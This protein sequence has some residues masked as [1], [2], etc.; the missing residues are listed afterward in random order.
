MAS[1]VRVAIIGLGRISR[2]HI[3]AI[4][5]WPELCELA[6]VIDTQEKLAVSFSE[7]F[8]VPYY[9]S[10]DEA[11][12][13][14]NIDAVVVCLPHLLHKE[15]AVKAAQ[16]GKHVLVE[17]VMAN[18]VPDGEAMVEAAEK[19]GVKLM[20]AQSRRFFIALQEAR[21]QR[22]KIGKITNM[23]YTFACYFDVNTAP[24]WWRSKEA[25]GGLVYPMLGSH[26]ID[27]TLWM[28][29]DRLPVSVFAQGASNNPDF[30][31]HDDVTIVIGFDDGTHATN[32]LSIN[33]RPSRHE[34]LMIGKEG[35]IYFSQAGDHIGLVGTA[36]TDLFVNGEL[37]MT[38]EPM[39]H[40]FAVQMKEFVESIREDR[41][42]VAS[43]REILLQLKIIEAAMRS[44]EEKKVIMLDKAYV[45]AQM[46]K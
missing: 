35:S 2:T 46:A 23:L 40:N 34:G 21:K 30:E 31:G 27:F 36:E 26:S 25:T 10:V 44:A 5:F 29:N 41:V 20:I 12:K 37:I 16:A 1:K 22:E 32:F 33:N 45:G 4:K 24:V 15:I 39:P 18:S 13:D 43:G 6:A 38:G 9:T 19:N 11:L 28:L 3:D 14:P 7:E 42:P 8:G 17:K